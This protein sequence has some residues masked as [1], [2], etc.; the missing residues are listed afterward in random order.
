MIECSE[1]ADEPV[2]LASA[3]SQFTLDTSDL[4]HHVVFRAV[5][6]YAEYRVELRSQDI[7]E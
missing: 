6:T 3:E 5:S 4:E 7:G 2:A 1:H